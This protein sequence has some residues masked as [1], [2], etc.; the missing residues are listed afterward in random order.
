MSTAYGDQSFNWAY[1]AL[2]AAPFLVGV[3]VAAVLAWSVGYRIRFVPGARRSAL[4]ES[5]TAAPLDNP[6]E[7]S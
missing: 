6:E 3:G 5:P 7:V 4:H 1:G 2:I